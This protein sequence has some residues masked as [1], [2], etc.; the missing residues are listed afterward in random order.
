MQS[1]YTAE[2]NNKVYTRGH[3]SHASLPLFVFRAIL[4]TGKFVALFK[5]AI[6]KAVFF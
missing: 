1:Q 3:L 2:T 6:L 4:Y 5:S